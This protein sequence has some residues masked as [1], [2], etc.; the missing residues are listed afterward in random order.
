MLVD[1]KKYGI[2][3]HQI[4]F[5]RTPYN[6]KN[7]KAYKQLCLI[8]EKEHFDIIHC[9]TPIGGVVGRL[10]GKKYNIKRVIYQAHGFHFYKGAPLFNW[11]VYYP[12]EKFLARYTDILITINK[13]DYRLSRKFKLKKN[14]KYYYIPGV[15]I[16]STLYVPNETIRE[17]KRT[18]MGFGKGDIIIISM[19]DLVNRKNYDLS[20]KAISKCDNLNIYYLICGKGPLEAKLKKEAEQLGI[21]D[22]VRFLGYRNDVIELLWVSDIFL[23]TSVQEGLSRSLMEG[24]ASGLP[25]VASDIRGNNDIIVNGKNGYLCSIKDSGIEFSKRIKELIINKELRENIKDNNLKSIKKMDVLNI[26]RELSN[27]YSK[28]I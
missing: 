17:K 20:L 12:I 16:D 22:R 1:E 11:L 7:I 8:E 28:F 5:I 23:L 15:G 6:L 21:K 27:I 9:N 25:C 18:E 24:M 26:S 10:L 4:D 14:G 2:H 3:I 19:G 13:E